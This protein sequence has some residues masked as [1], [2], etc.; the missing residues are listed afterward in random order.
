MTTS[1]SARVGQRSAQRTLHDLA[2]QVF[3]S[4]LPPPLAKTTSRLI[5]N[6]VVHNK[7][8]TPAFL[9]HRLTISL[10]LFIIRYLW[11]ALAPANPRQTNPPPPVKDVS[12]AARKIP[13]TQTKAQR[14]MTPAALQVVQLSLRG[15]P[16]IRLSR[17]PY[18]LRTTRFIV[19]VWHYIGHRLSDE[20]CRTRCNPAPTDGSMPDLVVIQPIPG[21]GARTRPAFNTEAAEQLNAWVDGYKGALNRMTD[22]NFVFVLYCVLF[23]YTEDW[24]YRRAEKERQAR[25]GE[26]IRERREAARA[27]GEE[28]EDGN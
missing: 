5:P 4:R 1:E 23:L 19:D 21:G 11:Q 24:K 6:D 16:E 15:R 12:P 28:L 3:R 13:T 18:P 7:L 9:S 14:R 10:D 27:A 20:L 25:N 22:Y 8:P 2:R 17:P 26:E